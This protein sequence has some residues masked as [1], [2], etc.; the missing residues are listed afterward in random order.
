MT[1]DLDVPAGTAT[2]IAAKVAALDDV[3]Y[4]GLDADGRDRYDRIAR[5]FL[6][7]ISDDDYHWGCTSAEA[8]EEAEGLAYDAG[9]ERG[10]ALAQERVIDGLAKLE[11][12]T[13]VEAEAV[14][15]ICPKIRAMSVWD[16]A[17]PGSY[18]RTMVTPSS[19]QA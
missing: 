14:V 7:L 5:L 13:M 1:V 3:T 19:E 12:A 11:R 4:A 16:D 8:A 17:A 9:I 18:E 2:E 15:M 10:F 6:D